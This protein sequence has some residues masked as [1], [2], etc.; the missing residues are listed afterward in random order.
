MATHTLGS[1]TASTA[2]GNTTTLNE[3][4]SISSAALPANAYITKLYGYFGSTNGGGMNAYLI[5]F[6]TNYNLLTDASAVV[7]GEA[8]QGVAI[9]PYYVASGT[10]VRVGWWAGAQQNFAVSSTGGWKG[11]NAGSPTNAGGFS[12]PGSPYYQGYPNWYLTWID[13]LSVSSVSPSSAQSGA[14]VTI[15][16]VGFTGGSI[17]GV[18][19]NGIGAS[20]SISSDS[21]IVATV[22][23]GA[24][25]GTLQVT[26][27]H[28]NG[29]T[30][31]TQ[32]APTLSAISPA[33]AISG[34][35][36][37]VTGYGYT[38]GAV[39]GV[40]FNG[41]AASSYSV[42]SNTQLT[43][44]VPSGYTTGNLTVTTGAGSGSISFTEGPPAIS[45]IS[46]TSA[47]VGQT[48][49]ITGYGYT[50]GSVTSVTFTPATGTPISASYTVTSNTQISAT[51]PAGASGTD[52]VTVNTNHG[53]ASSVITVSGA[54]VY[55]GSALQ[56]ATPYAY[57]GAN[58]QLAQIY[59]SD[60]TNI[61]QAQ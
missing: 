14:Q 44:T 13:A 57:D 54:H 60:G 39:S 3:I 52:T 35:T 12:Q 6:D 19:F 20:F 21:Q 5:L 55:D 46:P 27:D 2:G 45:G 9:T 18:T 34:T 10:V 4:V 15:N 17:T 8:W 47:G 38:D 53:S 61:V 7:Y 30:T 37:T 36:V 51:V 31:F 59:V 11:G 32:A 1:T 58:P 49:T 50:D 29:T 22:P 40:T 25:S 16:G 48:V 42:Q 56:N 28:G 41:I 23:H 26:S 24:T 43:A 33:T